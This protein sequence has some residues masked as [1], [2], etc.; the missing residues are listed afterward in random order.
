[1][2]TEQI[3]QIVDGAPEGTTHHGV[4]SFLKIPDKPARLGWFWGGVDKSWK[5]LQGASI[6]N[7]PDVRSL[8]DLR[9]ILTLRTELEAE[10]RRADELAAH[11]D[12]VKHVV[13]AYLKIHF[14]DDFDSEEKKTVYERAC[15]ILG[16]TPTKSLAAL[17]LEQQAKALEDLLD[18]D[19]GYL[20]TEEG[21]FAYYDYEI[22]G[23]IEQ[24][25]NQAK[26]Q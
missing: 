20:Q 15:D 22:S 6:A 13:N 5:S 18:S 17:K 2:K 3:Q 21:Q 10:K 9:E 14:D 19:T 4:G 7:F 16:Q 24:L 23:R 1:M 26:E 11:F 12:L 8:S 25:R